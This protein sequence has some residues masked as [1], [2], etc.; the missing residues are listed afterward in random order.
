MGI[1]STLEIDLALVP[2]YVSSLSLSKFH[3]QT[4]ERTV[5]MSNY[6]HLTL[7]GNYSH[8]TLGGLAKCEGLQLEY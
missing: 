8:L 6:S 4:T 5:V 2:S 1:V 3:K 7:G